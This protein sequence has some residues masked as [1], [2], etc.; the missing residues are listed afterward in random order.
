MF[1]LLEIPLGIV[2]K[3]KKVSNVYQ[4][5]N[6]TDLYKHIGQRTLNMIQKEYKVLCLDG[7][8]IKGALQLQILVELE[9]CTGKKCNEMFNFFAGTSIGGMIAISL[10]LG[11]SAQETLDQ[12]LKDRHRLFGHKNTMLKVGSKYFYQRYIKSLWNIPSDIYLY[13]DVELTDCYKEFYTSK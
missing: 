5:Q 12:L 13:Q 1:K 10:A 4:H 7:G 11:Q 2:N 9:R 3:I 8:G 6:N